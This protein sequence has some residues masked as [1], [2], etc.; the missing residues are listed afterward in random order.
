MTPPPDA[1]GA[2]MKFCGQLSEY[3]RT[4]S[5]AETGVSADQVDDA[6]LA[7]A[8]TRGPRQVVG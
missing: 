2:N 1:G 8:M 3:K 7:P 5:T 4:C 6:G